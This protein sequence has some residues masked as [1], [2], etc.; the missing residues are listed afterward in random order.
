MPYETFGPGACPERSCLR[1]RSRRAQVERGS[2]DAACAA[3]QALPARVGRLPHLGACGARLRRRGSRQVETFTVRAARP[4]TSPS[5]ELSIHQNTARQQGRLKVT[6]QA[7]D[8][9]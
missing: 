6:A 7:N 3:R 4:D 8:P 9:E 5:E 1:Q 2:H